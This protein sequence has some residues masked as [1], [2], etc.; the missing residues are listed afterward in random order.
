MHELF[1]LTVPIEELARSQHKTV[2]IIFPLSLQTIAV[3]L[4]ND[5]WRGGDHDGI[6]RVH[7][8]G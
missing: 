5:K 4:N 3:A 6:I 7:I 2:L 1:S 8:Q